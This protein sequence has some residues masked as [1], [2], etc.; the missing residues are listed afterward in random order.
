MAQFQPFDLNVPLN[1][2]VTKKISTFIAEKSKLK[3]KLL[4]LI[5]HFFDSDAIR[6]HDRPLR[7]RMLY[8]AELLNHNQKYYITKLK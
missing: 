5:F 1:K 3:L 6:M 4:K 8:P 2:R 7:R